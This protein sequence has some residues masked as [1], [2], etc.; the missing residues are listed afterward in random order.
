MDL[1]R[2]D[3][4]LLVLFDAVMQERNVT[5]AAQRLFLTQSAVS[6]AMAR[7]RLQLGDELFLRGAG[8]LRPT[9]RA[10]ELAPVV[11]GLLDELKRTL[12]PPRFDPA[13]AR[14][15]FTIA[16]SDYFTAVVAP[17]LFRLID[18]EAPG[19][20]VRI[21][22]TGGRTFELLDEGGADVAC[23]AWTDPAERYG[24]ELLLEED[25]VC[26]VR[27]GHPFASKPPSVAQYA[28]AKHVLVTPRG[29]AR[30]FIDEQ[31]AE[32]GLTRRV[33]MTVNHFAAAPMIVAGG[34]AVLTVPSLIATLYAPP[35]RTVIVPC[36][37]TAPIGLRQ[38]KLLWHERLGRH[39]AQAWFRAALHRAAREATQTAARA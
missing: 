8:K 10:L 36:P 33:V 26:V 25:Y 1:R 21:I 14:Q 27:R 29:D 35:R 17:A 11:H 30:G 32:R 23:T 2:L 34:D 22:P 3:L 38:M 15:A 39:P 24:A 13:T 5:R 16:T 6:N 7:L 20:D 12:D 31:L 37:L 18:R 9:P 19:V 4:N 28:K